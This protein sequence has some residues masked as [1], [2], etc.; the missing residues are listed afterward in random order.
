VRTGGDVDGV[1]ID[2][3]GRNEMMIIDDGCGNDSRRDELKTS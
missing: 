3:G 1:K 2:D